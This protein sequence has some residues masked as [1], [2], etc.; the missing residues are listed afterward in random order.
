MNPPYVNV[1]LKLTLNNQNVT[2][3]LEFT[4]FNPPTITDVD[5]RKGP[6]TGNTLVH[7][8]GTKINANRDPICFFAGIEATK[9]R[10]IGT[11]EI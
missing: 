11:K 5:P 6:T 2:E 9:V 7:I 1:Y 3:P 10:V 4:F 8:Y